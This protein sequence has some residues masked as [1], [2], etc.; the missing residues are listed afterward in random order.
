[1][2]HDIYP[3]GGAKE[4]EI[5]E[6][7]RGWWAGKK[8]HTALV[9]HSSACVGGAT[10]LRSVRCVADRRAAR[11]GARWI[12][13]SREST[14]ATAQHC[15]ELGCAEEIRCGERHTPLTSQLCAMETV[16]RRDECKATAVTDTCTVRSL[17]RTLRSELTNIAEADKAQFIA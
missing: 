13:R 8:K 16:W 12:S 3:D 11:G 6:K 15:E 14:G 2:T 7:K 10:E 4:K 9:T 5:K 17:S 1:M